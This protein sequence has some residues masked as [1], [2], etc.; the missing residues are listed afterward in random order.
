MTDMGP[1]TEV[2]L[3]ALHQAIIDAIKAKFPSLVTVEFYRE[4][5]KLTAAQLPACLLDL[6]EWE[7]APEDDDPQTEQLAVDARFEAHLILG[8][9][10]PE[11]KLAIRK[12]AAAFGAFLR[13][14]RWPG[15]ACGPAHV[16][17][18]FKDDFSPELDQYECWRVEWV[19]R[20]T[21]G[22]T[23]WEGAGITPETVFIGFT[24]R[25][26]VPHEADYLQVS[27]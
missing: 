5:R 19:Q 14:K 9:R 3:D 21:L 15:V 22:E 24:P 16:I 10:T 8:F 18:A 26:G 23:V 11:I 12:L 2:T 13:L 27:P 7:S 6:T 20:I 1:N 17:G 25:I 4:D